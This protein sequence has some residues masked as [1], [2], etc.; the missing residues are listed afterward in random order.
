[1]IPDNDGVGKGNPDLPGICHAF[2]PVRVIGHFDP[3]D[4]A[5]PGFRA[6]IV[7]ELHIIK[8]SA[9]KGGEQ[10]QYGL[11]VQ[12]GVRG[13]ADQNIISGII[14]KAFLYPFFQSAALK[15]EMRIAGVAAGIIGILGIIR[16]YDQGG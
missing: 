3:Q 8:K 11:R 15:G 12:F 1:M 7:N 14:A 6:V 13:F 10:G 2:R 9:G 16:L 4:A 5:L